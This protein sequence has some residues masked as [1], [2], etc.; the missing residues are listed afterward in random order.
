LCTQSSPLR[1]T[2]FEQRSLSLGHRASV[3]GA[4]LF[5]I[6]TLFHDERLEE[7][8]RSLGS[9]SGRALDNARKLVV[10]FL[11]KANRVVKGCARH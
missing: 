3:R 2:L 7:H 11:A 8:S 4:A 1:D 10:A 5:A 6:C 9:R